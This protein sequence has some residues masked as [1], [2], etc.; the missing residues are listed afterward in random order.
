LG[1]LFEESFGFCTSVPEESVLLEY[2]AMPL[3]NWLPCSE[4]RKWSRAK[5]P[6]NKNTLQ[7]LLTVEYQGLTVCTNIA[8]HTIQCTTLKTVQLTEK[9]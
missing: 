7:S 2:D 6:N 8:N 5:M 4:Q 1:V 9:V 3:G